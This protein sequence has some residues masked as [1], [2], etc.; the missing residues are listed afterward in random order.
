M[1]VSNGSAQ[2]VFQRGPFNE[3]TVKEALLEMSESLEGELDSEPHLRLDSVRGFGTVTPQETERSISDRVGPAG[4]AADTRQG[5]SGPDGSF[6]MRTAN[7][8][9]T[10]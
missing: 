8:S 1:A 2:G 5:G 7:G 10:S 4:V 3:M 6:E 9:H